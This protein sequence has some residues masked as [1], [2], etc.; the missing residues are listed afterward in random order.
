MKYVLFVLLSLALVF[1]GSSAKASHI[2]GAD[3]FYEYVSG[4][5]YKVSLVVYYDCSGSAFANIAGSRPSVTV[6]K[7]G[8][9]VG[10]ITL[11]Q[12]GAE[13]EVTP[14]CPAEKANTACNNPVNPL[15]GV[16]RITYSG[17]YNVTSTSTNW[18]FSFTGN[19]GGGAPQAGRSNSITNISVPSGSGSVMSLEALL[20]NTIGNN[21]SPKFTTIP[22]PFYCINVPQ[23]YNQGAVDVNND[24]LDY[25][26]APGLQGAG[27]VSYLSGYSATS[28]LAVAAGSFSFNN[29]TGQLNFT[30]NAVQRSLVV[31]EVSEYRN[32]TLVGTSSREMTFV[33][34]GTCN[35]KPAS[36]TIDTVK[37]NTKGGLLNTPTRLNV[38]QGTDSLDFNIIALNPANDTLIASVTGLPAGASATITSD[39]TTQ[40]IVK[41]KWAAAGAAPGN[42]NFFV[43]YKD[44]GC[45]LTSTQTVAYTIAVIRPNVL[46]NA[47]VAPTQC[48][49]KAY[50][51]YNFSYGLTPRT[52]TIKKSGVLIDSFISSASIAYDSL[53]FGLYDIEVKSEDLLCPSNFKLNV[54]DSG[55]YP[56]KPIVETPIFYCQ[57]DAA[58]PLKGTADSGAV[59]YWYN[60]IGIKFTIPPIP[61]THT[62]GIFLYQSNQKYKVCESLRDSILVYVTKRPIASFTGPDSLCLGDTAT[63]KFTGSVGVGPIVDYVWDFDGAGYVSGTEANDRHVLWYGAGEKLVTLRVDENKCASRTASKEVFVKPIPFAGFNVP[64]KACQYDT[65]TAFYNSKPLEGQQYVWKF[66]DDLSDSSFSPGPIKLSYNTPG[67][68]HFSL[69]AALNG[70]TDYRDTTIAIYPT[71]IATIETQEMPACIGDKIFLVASGGDKY[72]WSPSKNLFTDDKGALY[73]L[74]LEPTVYK[75]TATNDHGCVDSAFYHLR[76]VQP[77]CNFSYPNAFTPNNDQHNDRFKIVTYG[78]QITFQLSI[79]NQWGQRVYYGLDAAQGWDGTF[80]GKPCDAGTYFYFMTAKCYTG[81]TESHK[82]DVILIR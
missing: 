47:V 69:K 26:L 56:F 17:Y 5:N 66:A 18:V 20:N 36:S 12:E 65:I 13:V 15:P 29:I 74:A 42:Y 63:F 73:A 78:N 27:Y 60:P 23:Q 43:T 16:M 76:E 41:I 68:K 35:N 70:C 32:G 79:Y 1:N 8:M 61:A 46:Q 53:A 19:M 31:N 14:V 67:L 10:T 72:S 58:L 45:P 80:G 2:Y 7:N 39:T 22:T 21:S 71:P 59:L 28:P 57:N 54:V 6:K 33:V 4:N 34:L 77:C 24:S 62:P 52:V 25:S 49:H 48:V 11:T 30:P 75:L 55:I 38:C 3:F 82:G 37:A 40:P 81:K 44:N 51:K 50:V 64:N 9:A